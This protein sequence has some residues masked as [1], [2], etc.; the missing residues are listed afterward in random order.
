MQIR[1]AGSSLA[2]AVALAVSSLS[3]PA[4]TFASAGFCNQNQWPPDQTGQWVFTHGTTGTYDDVEGWVTDRQLLPCISLDPST[5]YA[6]A[7]AV[8][9]QNNT[10]IYQ[11]G[12]Y[13]DATGSRHFAWVNGSASVVN[14]IG[15]P[16]PSIGTRYHF[17]LYNLRGTRQFTIYTSDGSFVW[18]SGN[19]GSWPAGLDFAWWGYEVGNSRSEAGIVDGQGSGRADMVGQ[20]SLSGSS[21]LVTQPVVPGCTSPVGGPTCQNRALMFVTGG[22][23]IF[24]V[25]GT[26]T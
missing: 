10:S 19:A 8:N 1:R 15:S 2:I 3:N 26:N 24:N 11:L 23:T 14:I 16:R 21:T 20:Y 13:Q 7:A 18:S 22:G 9:V 6:F 5:G 25:Q 12:V 4:S 17:R